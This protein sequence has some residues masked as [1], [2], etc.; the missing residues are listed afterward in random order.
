[1]PKASRLRPDF[2]SHEIAN[3]TAESSFYPSD[4]ILGVLYRSIPLKKNDAPTD[5]LQKFGYKMLEAL[6]ALEPTLERLGL[7]PLYSSEENLLEEMEDTMEEYIL[8]L[9]VIAQTHTVSRRVNDRLTEAEL[10]SGTIQSKWADHRKRNDAV[11]AMNL[12]V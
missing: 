2:L 12:Q 7:P 5:G 11:T 8:Q 1:L 9:T 6:G 10:V 3:P 4:R